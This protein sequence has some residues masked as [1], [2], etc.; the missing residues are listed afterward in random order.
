M[1]LWVVWCKISIIFVIFEILTTSMIFF[2]FFIGAVIATIVSYFTNS[3]C[4][5]FIIFILT[6][7]FS[8]YLIKP[9][10]KRIIKRYKSLNS[11][12]DALIGANAIVIQKI[13]PFNYGLIKIYGEVWR[14]KSDININIG[15]IV[16]V[17]NITGTTLVVKK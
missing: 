7:I 16:S 12:V 10:S 3:N 4:T 13:T 17:E 14:A 9:I 1:I 8:I 2:C 6:A 5:A 11:N 15:E